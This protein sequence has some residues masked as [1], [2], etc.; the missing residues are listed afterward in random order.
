M[1]AALPKI[2][3]FSRFL[4]GGLKIHFFEGKT[5]KSSNSLGRG[6]SERLWSIV[7]ESPARVGA[8]S[9]EDEDPGSAEAMASTSAP[10]LESAFATCQWLLAC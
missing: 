1:K 2:I 3:F 10:M 8:C 4:G 5:F 7:T 9:P 6:P